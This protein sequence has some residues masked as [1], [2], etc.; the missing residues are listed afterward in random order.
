M[1]SCSNRV[2]I[3]GLCWHK[4]NY[5]PCGHLSRYFRY[6]LGQPL[7]SEHLQF[8]GW[9]CAGA[10]SSTLSGF[11]CIRQPKCE[12]MCR[13]KC[14]SSFSVLIM[15]LGKSAPTTSSHR[16][17]RDEGERCVCIIL[18][19]RRR[20]WIRTKK[21]KKI[22]KRYIL[23][24]SFSWSKYYWS[25]RDISRVLRNPP[26]YGDFF[27]PAPISTLTSAVRLMLLS[28]L[29]GWVVAGLLRITFSNITTP[30]P[31]R[32]IWYSF[33]RPCASVGERVSCYC[34]MKKR[35]QVN[36]PIALW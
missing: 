34:C 15:C 14:W 31:S 20:R 26:S 8:R 7:S 30:P 24:V 17:E 5:V 19:G 35:S 27:F 28:S 10:Y 32:K 18:C 21:K 16:T 13:K 25:M 11:E 22:A 29:L 36:F 1:E 33:L 3:R 9:M 6:L 12:L 23:S 2:A 4:G